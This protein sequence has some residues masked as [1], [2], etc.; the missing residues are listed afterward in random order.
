M[1]ILRQAGQTLKYTP[2][3]NF[4]MRSP[5][6]ANIQDDSYISSYIEIRFSM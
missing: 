2:N 3:T 6:L 5:G 1:F 4:I